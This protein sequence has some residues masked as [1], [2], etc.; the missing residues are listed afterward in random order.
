MLLGVSFADILS[1]NY[2][3]IRWAELAFVKA[4]VNNAMVAASLGIAPGVDLVMWT[5]RMCS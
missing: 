1:R 4:N 5:I 2:E 3:D